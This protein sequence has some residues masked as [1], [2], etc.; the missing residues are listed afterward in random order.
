MKKFVELTVQFHLK[1]HSH[2][3]VMSLPGTQGNVSKSC[4]LRNELKNY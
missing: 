2:K 3:D 1:C 4:D